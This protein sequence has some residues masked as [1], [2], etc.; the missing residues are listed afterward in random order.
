MIKTTRKRYSAVNTVVHLTAASLLCFSATSIAGEAAKAERPNILVIMADDLGYSD[1]SAFGGEIATPNI[2]ALAANGRILTNFHTAAVCSPTR[3]SLLSGVDHHLAGIGNM[4]EVV[5]LNIHINKPFT[6]PWGESNSYDFSNIPDGYQGHLS[7]RVVSMAELFRDAGYQ[8]SMVGKWHLGYQVVKP[9]HRGMSWYQVRE[10]SLPHNR[11]F[12]NTFAMINGAGAHFAPPS[13]PTPMDKTVYEENGRVFPSEQ[14][15]K[16]FYST[17]TYTDKLISYID[18]SRANNKPFFAYAAYTAPHWPLQA[19]AEDIAKQKGRYDEGFEVIR[20]RRIARMKTLGLIPKDFTPSSLITT[21][22]KNKLWDQLNDEEKAR[23]ARLMEVYAA[24]VANLDTHIGRLINHL[25]AIG[26]YDNTLIMFMSDNGAEG[27]PPF[28]PPIPGTEIDNSL[29]N[30]GHPGSLAAYGMR[31]AEVSA[32]PF[33]LFKG[34]TGA[35]GSTSSP[36]IVQLPHQKGALPTS[37][38]RMHVMDVLPTLLEIAGIEQPGQEYKGRQVHP[39]EGVSW[40][41][42]LQSPDSF[43]AVRA[44]DAVLADELMGASYVLKG[45]WKLSQQPDF[46]LRPVMRKTVPLKLYNLDEDRGETRDLA[47]QHPDIV[48]DLQ[49]AYRAYIDRAEVLEHARSASGR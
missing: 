2:D 48:A 31:W 36:L 9:Q 29:D 19:P 13:P 26:E 12:E 44:D 7:D 45:P 4:A 47:S 37:D 16:D 27:A 38:A 39:I 17:I 24:M 3:A 43:D 23:E 8:T 34:F 21:S 18:L 11:G 1:I 49:Q 35:E 41:S 14:L 22:D 42:A 30:I 32:A 46:S 25:K 20:D 15:P 33:R 5:G 40:L 6:A 28:A 10:A